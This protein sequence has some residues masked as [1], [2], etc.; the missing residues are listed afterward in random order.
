MFSQKEKDQ[1]AAEELRV[2]TIDKGGD[3][4]KSILVSKRS[5]GQAKAKRALE[6]VSHFHEPD[7]QAGAGEAQERGGMML[8]SESRV[9]MMGAPSTTELVAINAAASTQ[10]AER[11]DGMRQTLDFDNNENGEV[12]P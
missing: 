6:T 12:I 5:Q 2:Q 3:A 11:T 4:M 10:K 7:G 1:I 8:N 9:T